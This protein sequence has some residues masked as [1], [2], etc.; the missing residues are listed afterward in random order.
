MSASLLSSRG[1]SERA[2]AILLIAAALRLAAAGQF[3]AD[4]GGKN[5]EG[6]QRNETAPA[7]RAARL[8]RTRNQLR[9]EPN[10]RF[11]RGERQL[12]PFNSSA[13]RLQTANDC[14]DRDQQERSGEYRRR[15]HWPVAFGEPNERKERDESR[16]QNPA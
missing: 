12:D 10:R 5:T 3:H 13:P 9:V 16:G 7:D 11:A 2:A 1:A 4:S 14:D 6:Y 8:N 15:D